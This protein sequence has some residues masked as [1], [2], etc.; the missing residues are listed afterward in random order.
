MNGIRLTAICLLLLI[1]TGCG[2]TASKRSAGYADLDALSWRDVDTT[3]T[4]SLGPSLL[5][6]AAGFVEDDPQTQAMLRGLE[7]VRVKI[8]EIEGDPVDV[9]AD[10]DRMS[11]DLVGQGWEPVVLVR[12]E[13]ETTH[14]LVKVVDEQIA[15]ITVL[16]SDSIEVV[17][18]NVMGELKPEMFSRTMVA[19]NAPMPDS[20]A[21]ET[22]LDAH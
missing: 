12:E 11:V 6:L 22:E 19:L 18:V 20:V 9:A 2:I 7:G 21:L 17:L 8:Y 15:G 16:T 3:M 1:M 14:M 13:G 10:L 4:L 5:S